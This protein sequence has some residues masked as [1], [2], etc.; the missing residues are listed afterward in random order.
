M[1][2]KIVF[3]ENAQQTLQFAQTGNVDAAVIPLSLLPT[4]GTGRLIEQA[5][6]K[7]VEQTRVVCRGRRAQTR[8]EAHAFAHFLTSS[9]G[10]AV[11]KKYGFLPPLNR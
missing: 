7:P 10:L 3:A 2:A 8:P 5:A 6:H 1:Q 9:D 4:N 11:L